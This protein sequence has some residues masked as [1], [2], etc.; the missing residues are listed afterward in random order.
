[1]AHAIN[2]IQG[3]FIGLKLKLNLDKSIRLKWIR[4]IDWFDAESR[5]LLCDEKAYLLIEEL[6]DKRVLILEQWIRAQD[7]NKLFTFCIDTP[8]SK[9]RVHLIAWN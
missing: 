9:L 5:K 6:L 8:R 7:K 4:G 2:W 3:E 1:M